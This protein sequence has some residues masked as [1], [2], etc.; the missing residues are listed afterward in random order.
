MKNAEEAAGT[1]RRNRRGQG[2]LLRED[3]LRAAAGMIEETGS[4]ESVTLRSVAREVGI[5]APSIYAHFP[6]REAIVDAVID[7]AFA[8]LSAE[9]ST[10]VAAYTDPVDRLLGGCQAYARFATDCPGRY[11][12]LFGRSP[13]PE[14]PLREVRMRAFQPLVDSVAEAVQGGR[15]SSTDPFGDATLIWT[16]LHGAV[17]LRTATPMFPWPPLDTVVEELVRR[18]GRIK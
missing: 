1:R 16:G 6:D 10:A 8:E 4:D 3:I 12:M 15:S 9:V 2:A 17:A 11:R 13:N 7:D 14:A 5:A 18:L